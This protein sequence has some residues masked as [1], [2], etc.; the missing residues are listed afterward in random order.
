MIVTDKNP[1]PHAEKKITNIIIV[2]PLLGD[3]QMALFLE[4]E[5]VLTQKI[6]A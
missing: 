6:P 4:S 3:R 5:M 2:K 1:N